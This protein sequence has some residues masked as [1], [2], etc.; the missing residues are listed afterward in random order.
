MSGFEWFLLV[1]VV[2]LVPL[3]IA[4]AVTLWTLEQARKRNRRNRPDGRQ[5]GVKRQATRTASEDRASEGV[6]ESEPDR[7]LDEPGVAPRDPRADQAAESDVDD[8]S[9]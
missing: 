4:I 1:V 2:I 8:R 5:P 3:A 6:N 9:R 7:R